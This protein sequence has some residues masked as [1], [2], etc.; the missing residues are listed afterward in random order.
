MPSGQGRQAEQGVVI[1]PRCHKGPDAAY[2]ELAPRRGLLLA[3]LDGK[4][5]EAAAAVN[6]ALPG[7]A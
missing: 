5:R 3:T 7:I 4:L 1:G 2:L 6:V